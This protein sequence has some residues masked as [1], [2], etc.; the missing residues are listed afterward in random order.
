MKTEELEQAI[1]DMES[2][3]EDLKG[4][5]IWHRANMP[6]GCECDPDDWRGSQ[7]GPICNEFVENDDDGLCE[8][9][10][11]LEECHD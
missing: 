2:E 9:C 1:A 8:T 5:L 7:P 4:E 3:L 11:H 10:A 6:S